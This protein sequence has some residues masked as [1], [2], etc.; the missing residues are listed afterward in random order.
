MCT[1]SPTQFVG[2]GASLSERVRALWLLPRGA[3][4]RLAAGLRGRALLLRGAVR[5]RRG[6][7]LPVAAEDVRGAQ[8]AAA[9]D[10]FDQQLADPL[11][12]VVHHRRA[13]QHGIAA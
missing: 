8:G 5:Q 3:A 10:V 13:D 1:P 9:A 11:A 7:D 12:A 4:V 6:D 2:E